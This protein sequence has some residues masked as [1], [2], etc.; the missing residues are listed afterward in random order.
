[1]IV[2]VMISSCRS[3][4]KV[5]SVLRL[6][7]SDSIILVVVKK[8]P[9]ACFEFKNR[10]VFPLKRLFLSGRALRSTSSLARLGSSI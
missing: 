8:I 10:N 6:M 9:L 7:Y 3:V 5:K 1:M 4:F 2:T